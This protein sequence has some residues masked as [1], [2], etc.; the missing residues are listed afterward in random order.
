MAQIIGE[1]FDYTDAG[2]MTRDY[3]AS[4][5]CKEYEELRRIMSFLDMDELIQIAT[6]LHKVKF[7][8]WNGYYNEDFS[9]EDL[10]KFTET[11]KLL[12]HDI[13]YITDENGKYL[14]E[15]KIQVPRNDVKHKINRIRKLAREG[16]YGPKKSAKILEMT[17]E[18]IY[19]MPN[20]DD[21]NTHG[22]NKYKKKKKKKKSKKK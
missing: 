13:M 6:K 17:T 3:Q 21:L 4:R 16:Y 15:T 7:L 18:E 22:K 5:L 10:E 19:T 9:R 2:V 8:A 12:Q 1:Y 14:S 11:K 20:Y